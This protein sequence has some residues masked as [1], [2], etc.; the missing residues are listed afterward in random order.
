MTAETW[1]TDGSKPFERAALIDRIEQQEVVI[2]RQ[3]AELHAARV[4]LEA[5]DAALAADHYGGAMGALRE[6][7][8]VLYDGDLNSGQEK[9]DKVVEEW[10]Q[11]PNRNVYGLAADILTALGPVQ[12]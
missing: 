10:L 11:D 7:R 2:R 8:G 3:S 4:K 12:R 6:L 9:A 1:S 5:V